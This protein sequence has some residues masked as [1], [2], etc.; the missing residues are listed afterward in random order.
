[1]K[2][3]QIFTSLRAGMTTLE[4]SATTW[5][6]LKQELQQEGLLSGEMKAAV[7]ELGTTLDVD[8]AA[9]PT[10]QGIGGDHDFTLFLSP[11]KTKSGINA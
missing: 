6:Q 11:V 1:M 2:K 10:G 8:S 3:V 4:T 7:K 5:G 9:L